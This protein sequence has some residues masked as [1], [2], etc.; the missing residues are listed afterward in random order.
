MSTQ[1]NANMNAL[2][3]GNLTIDDNRLYLF[4]VVTADTVVTLLGGD[5]EPFTIP[6]GGHWNP[7]PCPINAMTLAGAGTM[8]VG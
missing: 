3:I 8:V 6:A 1:R 4:I 7:V 5:E 2:P